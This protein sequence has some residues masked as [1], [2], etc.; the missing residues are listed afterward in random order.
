MTRRLFALLAIALLSACGVG[1]LQLVPDEYVSDQYSGFSLDGTYAIGADIAFQLHV[2]EGD[3]R[4]PSIEITGSAIRIDETTERFVHATATDAGSGEIIYR[5]NDEE[6]RRYSYSVSAIEHIA[7]EHYGLDYLSGF[8]IEDGVF[9]PS[10]FSIAEGTRYG[11]NIRYEDAEGR[12]LAGAGLLSVQGDG[13]AEDEVIGDTV[14]FNTLEA[15]E[16]SLVL[17]AGGATTT[18][19]YDVVDAIAS[20]SLAEERPTE[21]LVQIVANAIDT[22]G[23]PVYCRPTW[24]LNG[25]DYEQ[26]ELAPGYALD[27]GFIV[28]SPGSEQHIVEATVLNSSGSIEAAFAYSE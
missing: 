7:V 2:A 11:L 25:V 22:E 5:M 18:L 19:T 28:F 24:R 6:V 20:L 1:D 15:G 13:I 21:E 27:P 12:V 17:S 23:R 26:P 10:A 3:T 8:T 14:L 4:V 9:D 16:F